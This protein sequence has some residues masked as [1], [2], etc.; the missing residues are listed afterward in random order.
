MVA[1]SPTTHIETRA[2]VS[3]PIEGLDQ[4]RGVKRIKFRA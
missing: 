2:C 4:E 3:T 1:C